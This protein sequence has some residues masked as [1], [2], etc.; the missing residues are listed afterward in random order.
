MCFRNCNF[1]AFIKILHHLQ[2]D[3]ILDNKIIVNQKLKFDIGRVENIVGKGDIA[4]Y[5]HCLLFPRSF[6][7][8]FCAWV[9][10]SGDFLWKRVD[11]FIQ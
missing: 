11:V 4:G 8:A 3:K 1:S 10:K 9:V 5:Q 6:L 7:K 2:N